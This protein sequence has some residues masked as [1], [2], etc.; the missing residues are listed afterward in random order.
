MILLAFVCVPVLCAVL[1]YSIPKFPLRVFT[2]LVELFLFCVFLFVFVHIIKEGSITQVLGAQNPVLGIALVAN[3]YTMALIGICVVLFS[4]CFVYTMRETFFDSK[5]VMLFLILQGLLSGVFLADDLFTIFVLLEVATVVVAILIM[6]KRDLR[7][8]YDGMVYLLSQVICML[9]YL[10]GVGYLYKIFGVLSISQIREMMPHANSDDLIVP[11]AFIM[12][13][14]CLKSAFFPLFSWL[15]RAHA[16]PSAPSAVSAILSGLYVKNGIYLFF[17]FTSMF[18]AA[19][20]DTLFF[21]WIAAGTAIVGFVMALSQ[22]DIKLILA[23]HTISQIGLIALGLTVPSEISSYGALYHIICH[24]VFK[25]LL[26]LSAGMI[27]KQYKTRDIRKIHGVLKTMPI[28]GFA[29]ILG[30]LGISGAPFFNASVSKYFMQYGVKDH[31]LEL[32]FLL[33]NFGTIL[34][35]VKYS[36]MLWGEPQT[37]VLQSRQKKFVLLALGFTCL[38]GGVFGTAFMNL[39]FDTSLQITP[40]L[41]GEKAISYLI[42]VL[43][44]FA[45]YKFF[46]SKTTKL[47][48]LRKLSFHFQQIVMA[49]LS[50]YIILLFSLRVL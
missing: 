20:S 12:T 17:V 38:L 21:T 43:L 26:F 47:Y 42:S 24:A 33:I 14:I 8:V 36:H 48:A 10:F 23:F 50:F 4:A 32:L 3:R 46:L 45:L 29:T 49:I 44:A 9:F 35:F 37:R 1:S 11:F 5:F 27:I 28:T 15:P 6:Y 19:I 22:T 18:S 34:S 13:A 39:M 41:Y 25:S 31:P 30:I 7:S 16:T 2:V 40:L